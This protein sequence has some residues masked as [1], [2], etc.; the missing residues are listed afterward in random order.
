MTKTLVNILLTIILVF[1][2]LFIATKGYD[3]Y[4]Y[5]ADKFHK[6]LS[7]TINI[8]KEV[9]E[10]KKTYEYKKFKNTDNFI[11]NNKEELYNIYYTVLNNGWDTFTFYCP[12]EYTECYK[13]V[14]EIAND[15]KL[16]TL[17][18][19]FVSPYNTYVHYNTVISNENEI[20]LNI[21]KL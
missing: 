3:T 5:I 16:L 11:P 21:I 13:D 4:L 10:Y 19:N 20:Y 6:Y 1:I 17:M 7:N 14:N 15:Q 18:N 8:P 2:L 12:L 9:S